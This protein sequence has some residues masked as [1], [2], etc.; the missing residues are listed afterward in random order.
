MKKVL[1]TGGLILVALVFG[2]CIMICCDD[3]GPDPNTEVACAAACEPAPQ[4]GAATGEAI[5]AA[6]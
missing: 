2:G 4:Q 6:P 1:L 3:T 5:L